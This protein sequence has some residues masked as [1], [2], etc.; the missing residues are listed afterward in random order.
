LNDSGVGLG[1]R[2]Q[3]T[4]FSQAQNDVITLGVD[5]FEFIGESAFS[6]PDQIRF[7][8]SGGNTIV[9]F[10]T[11]GVSGAEMQIELS[12]IINL[13]ASDFIL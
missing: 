2:D 6:A 13:N 4:D 7:S 8:H 5:D 10:N 11:V 9:A 12:G 3:I 1:D